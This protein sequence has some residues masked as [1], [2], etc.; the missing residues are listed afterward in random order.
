MKNNELIIVDDFII[1][2]NK[3]SRNN[4]IYVLIIL[5]IRVRWK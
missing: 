3:N 5:L 1:F 2:L 4:K